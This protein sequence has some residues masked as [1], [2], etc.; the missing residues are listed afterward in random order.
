VVDAASRTLDR[1]RVLSGDHLTRGSNPLK[2]DAELCEVMTTPLA[3]R[4]QLRGQHDPHMLSRRFL[5]P[6]QDDLRQRSQLR[7]RPPCHDCILGFGTAFPSRAYRLCAREAGLAGSFNVPQNL[8]GT[9]SLAHTSPSSQPDDS[10]RV[11]QSPPPSCRSGV[12]VT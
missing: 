11:P 6:L 7:I 5:R 8:Q 10:K 4:R 9:G 1:P 3:H 12:F 2:P